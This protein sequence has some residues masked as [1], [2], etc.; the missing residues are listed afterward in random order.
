MTMITVALMV[1]MRH[2]LRQAYLRPYLQQEIVKVQSQ[3]GVIVLFLALF[4]AGL[5]TVAYMFW[6]V[7]SAK[8]R[9]DVELVAHV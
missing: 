5:A 2:L 3:V 4:V 7:Q 1:T 9:S 6:K 8:R